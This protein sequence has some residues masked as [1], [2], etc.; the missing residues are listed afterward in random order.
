[1]VK[2]NPTLA[3]TPTFTATPSPQPASPTYPSVPE[4]TVWD[5]ADIF[6]YLRSLTP[7]PAS[8]PRLQPATPDRSLTPSPILGV[9]TA[10]RRPLSFESPYRP[11]AIPAPPPPPAIMPPV[12]PAMGFVHELPTHLP[13]HTRTPLFVTPN[14]KVEYYAF[15][16]AD[17]VAKVCM[18]GTVLDLQDIYASL[19]ASQRRMG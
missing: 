18:V 14:G 2:T 19:A 4:S 6:Q 12:L 8:T 16:D 5:E 3:P 1:M 11:E 10:E 9:F 7:S 13:P 15:A 17:G